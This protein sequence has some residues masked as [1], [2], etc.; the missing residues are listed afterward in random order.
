MYNSY[1]NYVYP[2]PEYTRLLTGL[3]LSS[4][5]KVVLFL[6]INSDKNNKKTFSIKM[7]EDVG[8]S[9]PKKY[10]NKVGRLM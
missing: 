6:I 4:V 7:K 3:K 5:F 10:A 1:I 8:T 2:L 9:K